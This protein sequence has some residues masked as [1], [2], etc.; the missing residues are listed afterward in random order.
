MLGPRLAKK[1]NQ[2][3]DDD[4]ADGR[5]DGPEHEQGLPAEAVDE[6]EADDGASQLGDVDDAGLDE[7]LLVGE[8]EGC[9]HGG[10]VV[11][12]GVD[13]DHLLEEA[14]EDRD[15]GA[16]PASGPPGVYPGPEVQLDL[17][18]EGARLQ[19]GVALD[20]DLAG[21]PVLGPHA[22]P[23]GLDKDVVGAALAELGEHGQGLVVAALHGEPPR[24]WGHREGTNEEN[25]T[26]NHLQPEGNAE[27]RGAGQV[28]CS[29][30][31]PVRD[32]DSEDDEQ[33]V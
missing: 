4:H 3:A 24:A 31:H 16:A 22:K 6:E 7:L 30:A 19:L 26:R 10:C 8:A 13:A 27:R 18:L 20:L 14:H 5:P 25:D 32:H 9:D 29:E 11:N 33:L 2:D 1:L 28:P 21:D 15:Q 17:V 12:Q 23:F